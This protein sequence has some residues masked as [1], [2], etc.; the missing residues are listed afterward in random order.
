MLRKN[1]QLYEQWC[2]WQVQITNHTILCYPPRTSYHWKDDRWFN[3]L[4]TRHFD[5]WHLFMIHTTSISIIIRFRIARKSRRNISLCTICVMVCLAWSNLQAH[6]NVLS[7]EKGLNKV[8]GVSSHELR[9]TNQHC[10]V[11]VLNLIDFTMHSKHFSN[12]F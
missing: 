5:D 12:I 7:D 8:I 4:K 2:L 3:S 1:R 6:T 10:V 11:N 9:P